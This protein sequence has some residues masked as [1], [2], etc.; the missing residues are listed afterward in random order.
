MPFY[1]GITFV[2]DADQVDLYQYGSADAYMNVQQSMADHA[3]DREFQA[4][5]LGM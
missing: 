1:D 3:K 4:F 5:D 2:E